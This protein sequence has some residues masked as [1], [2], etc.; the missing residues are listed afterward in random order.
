MKKNYSQPELQV[1]HVNAHDVIATSNRQ[2]LKSLERE[3]W[4]DD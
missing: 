2:Q 4:S 3:E 1:I